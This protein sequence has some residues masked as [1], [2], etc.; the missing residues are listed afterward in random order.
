MNDTDETPHFSQLQTTVKC[1]MQR[2][3]WPTTN[4]DR[5]MW[6]ITRAEEQFLL[7]QIG[8]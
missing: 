4:I 3:T 5:E 2:C 8:R 6:N 7:S 1:A